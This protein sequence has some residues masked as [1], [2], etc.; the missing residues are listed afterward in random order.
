M[1]QRVLLGEKRKFY[2]RDITQDYHCQYGFFTVEDLKA[3]SGS[4]IKSN[5]GK[6]LVIVDATVV[7]KYEKLSRGP[8]IVPRKDIGFFLVECGITKESKILDAGSGSGA[9]ACMMARFAKEVDTCEIR[10]DHHKIVKKNIEQL[11]LNNVQ[12]HLMSIYE[13]CPGKEY[14]AFFLDV[15][16][17][18]QAIETAKKAL[19]VGGFWVSY[20][21]CVPQVADFVN[22]LAEHSCFHVIKTVEVLEREWDVKGR[23]VRPK[24]Q[25]IGHSGFLTLVRKISL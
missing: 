19:K 11:E 20:S 8:Q 2:I 17:P 15:P 3:P 5:K 10:E 9:I 4:T 16:E 6:E 18:W 12:A 21:P 7:D 13:E 25:S 23:K 14:D 22:T 1:I 24:S